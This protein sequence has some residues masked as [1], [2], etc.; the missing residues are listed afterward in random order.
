MNLEQIPVRIIRS[1]RRKTS[2]IKIL[3][4]AVEVRVP[5]W[6]DDSYIR[7]LLHERRDWIETHYAK[8]KDNQRR[9]GLAVT[10]GHPWPFKGQEYSLLWQQG[11]KAQVCADADQLQVVISRRSKL[12]EAEQVSRQLKKWYQHEAEIELQAR[13]D[14]WSKAMGLTYR[15]LSVKSY[16]KRWGSCSAQ[17]DI[18]LNWRLIMLPTPLIDYVVIHELAHITHFNHSRDF[19]ALVA[20]YCTD[21][22]TLRHDLN[23]RVSLLQW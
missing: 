23:Q 13:L 3:E 16:R 22:K 12:P 6:V 21:W 4:P 17:T 15:S 20:C 14:Y 8:L 10:Q 7:Q 11:V 18:S 9:F 2:V 19:W 5:H 1:P